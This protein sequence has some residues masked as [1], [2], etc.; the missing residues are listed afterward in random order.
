MGEN[1]FRKSFSSKPR[2]LAATVNFIFWKMAFCWPKFSPLTWK[3]FYTLIFTSNHFQKE[4]ERERERERREP[5][6]ESTDRRA[7]RSSNECA[8]WSR[9]IATIDERRARWTIAPSIAISRRSRSRRLLILLGLFGFVFSF[10]FSKHQK[11]FSRK[12]FEMQPNTWKYFPFRK[13]AFPENGIFFGNT[14][15][16]TKHSL[17]KCVKT[18]VL[19]IC[20]IYIYIYILSLICALFFTN[21]IKRGNASTV[22]LLV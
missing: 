21:Y 15:T 16:Q 20:S 6:S 7:V 4:R 13:I 11:I 1:N 9:S 18:I 8:R 19:L 3:W 17:S 14:F 22:P 5:R 10:F 12:F 2:C